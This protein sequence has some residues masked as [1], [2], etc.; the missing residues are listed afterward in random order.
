[1]RS[2][3]RGNVQDGLAMLLL[4]SA[5]LFHCL[6]KAGTMRQ[7]TAFF[8][9]P[10][11]FPI[12]LSGCGMLLG[13]L[14]TISGLCGK[15]NT[16]ISQGEV[17]MADFAIILALT[18]AYDALLPHLG[19]VPATA[20]YLILSIFWLGERRVFILLPVSLATPFVLTLIFRTGLGVRL[21]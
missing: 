21:P 11:F 9:S 19:F 17:R 14:L 6:V 4:S 2:L 3:K 18:I 16:K 12:I 20:L 10:Y 15:Q 13:V 5:L 7:K 8:M 1:M